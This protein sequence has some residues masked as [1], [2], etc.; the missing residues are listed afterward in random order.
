M[1]LKEYLD[2][3]VVLARQSHGQLTFGLGAPFP[4]P[5][6][7]RRE[8]QVLDRDRRGMVGGK[9]SLATKAEGGGRSRGEDNR[10][11]KWRQSDQGKTS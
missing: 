6:H 8:L 2:V 5:T 9:W 7:F 10:K 1:L 11:G 3:I 4:Q